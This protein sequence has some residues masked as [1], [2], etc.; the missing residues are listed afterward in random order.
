MECSAE[1]VIEFLLEYL[2]VRRRRVV[3][4]GLAAEEDSPKVRQAA[5]QI[6]GEGCLKPFVHG[7]WLDPQISG[8]E[9]AVEQALRLRVRYLKRKL[10]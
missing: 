6:L 2:Q 10:D 4:V 9:L 5:I 3:L 8:L 1:F 7:G